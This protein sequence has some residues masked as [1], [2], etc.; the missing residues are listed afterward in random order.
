MLWFSGLRGAMA[1][2]L[3]AQ[4]TVSPTRQMFFTT[5]CIVVIATVI[6]VGWLTTPA[7]TWL[8]VRQISVS[9]W[10]ATS[11]PY[12]FTDTRGYFRR[13]KRRLLGRLYRNAPWWQ[14]RPSRGPRPLLGR[15]GPSTQQALLPGQTVEERRPPILQTAPHICTANIDWN[16]AKLVF[17]TGEMSDLRW[18]TH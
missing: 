17:A 8:D 10:E 12:F 14:P 9:R 7:L 1:F 2:A 16:D 11:V 13:R 15:P 5:T 18:S 3:A 6:I 4:N